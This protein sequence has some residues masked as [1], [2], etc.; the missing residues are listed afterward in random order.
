MILNCN[1]N[2]DEK[3]QIHELEDMFRT[4]AKNV[5]KIIDILHLFHYF[6]FASNSLLYL[7][8]QCLYSVEEESFV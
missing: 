8:K 3:L 1:L 5:H 7:N 6:N 2:S 4:A